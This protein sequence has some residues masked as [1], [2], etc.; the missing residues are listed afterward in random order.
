MVRFSECNQ[1]IYYKPK[2]VK[3][4]DIT[5]VTYVLWACPFKSPKSHVALSP[6]TV[7]DLCSKQ[8]WHCLH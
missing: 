2:P 8:S 3:F 4:L 5:T 7:Y 6:A 1:F